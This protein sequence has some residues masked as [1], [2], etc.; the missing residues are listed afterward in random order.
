[1]TTFY[2]G[3]HLDKQTVELSK[4]QGVILFDS[5]KK[6]WRTLTKTLV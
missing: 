2:V 3:S 1:M 6:L 4:K 5:V